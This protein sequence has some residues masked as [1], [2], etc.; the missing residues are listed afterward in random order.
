MVV[1]KLV[2]VHPQLVTTLLMV[3]RLPPLFITGTATDTL[4]GPI[5]P[6]ST[7]SVTKRLELGAAVHQIVAISIIAMACRKI[8]IKV[9]IYLSASLP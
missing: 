7:V 9:S 2:V 3:T 1:V 8:R 4:T 5:R 6:R